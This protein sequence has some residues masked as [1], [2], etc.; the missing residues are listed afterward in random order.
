MVFLHGIEIWEQAKAGS[1]GACRRANFLVSNSRYTRDRANRCHGG[2][3]RTKICWLGTE[4]DADADCADSRLETGPVVLVVARMD[5]GEGYKGHDE[6]IR[7]WPE[8]LKAHPNARLEIVGRGG[9]LPQLKALAETCGVSSQVIFLGFVSETQLADCYARASVFALPSRGEGF[10]LVYIE[11]M[12][13]RLP[14]LASRHDAGA[15]VVVDGETGVLVDLDVPN[16][17][18]SKLD[19]LLSN[20]GPAK[21]MGLAGRERWQAHFT[22]RAFKARFVP[23]IDALLQ[24][25]G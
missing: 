3:E 7:A 2:F 12:R 16:D 24:E 25:T 9:L 20:P 15:E 19:W 10:G 8:V 11:A 14:V 5:P 18:A 17:L 21:S 22:Y 13:N 4:K 1:V 23:M 6:L